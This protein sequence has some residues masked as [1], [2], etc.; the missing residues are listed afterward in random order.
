MPITV[1]K[2]SINTDY[3]LLECDS[4]RRSFLNAPPNSMKNRAL[5]FLLFACATNVACNDSSNPVAGSD[6][7]VSSSP[8]LAASKSEPIEDEYIV[9]FDDSESGVEVRAAKLVSGQKGKLKHTFKHGL[10]GFSATLTVDA[11][12]AIAN[13]PGV[14]RVESDV[15]M[16][17]STT[18]TPPSWGL[19]RID[20]RPLPLDNSY[21]FSSVGSGVRVYIVDTGILTGH[22]EFGSRAVSG[23]TAVSDGNGTNDCNGHGTHVA[24]TVGGATTGIAR[25]AQLVAVRV[26]DCSGSGTS[27]GVIA[28]IDWVVS[29][30][31]ANP[32]VPMVAN[33]SLGGS[34]NTSLND[35]VTR[36][37]AAGV[38]FA[39]AAG[40]SSV[41]A[42]TQ[43]PAATPGALTVGATESSDVMAYYSNFGT[44]LDIFAPGSGIVSAWYNG[45]Y[46]NLSG[47]SMAAPH[48]AGVAAIIL[49]DYP[50]Y[51]P[52]QVRS[53]LVTGA[54]TN[55]LSGT[56]AGSPNVLLSNLYAAAAPPPPPPP[57]PTPVTITLSVTGSR[58][59]NK[60]NANLFWGGATASTVSVYR[61]GTLRVNTSNDG[62]YSERVGAG[63]FA[64]KVCQSTSC[65]SVVTVTF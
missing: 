63:S 40:N 35:A 4:N 19:D 64:Y 46:A 21:T 8:R 48:V 11:A 47:T 30:K 45:G 37:I 26:L 41:D 22:Q 6:N 10:K 65:S 44:C 58:T 16:Q 49:G 25:A 7:I 20:Q 60:N 54:T 17:A 18:V 51:S 33:L 55:V 61:N 14:A 39:V 2:R 50:A 52:S 59:G 31:Q 38:V 15:V 12:A 9:T 57:P 24:G 3:H 53:A 5:P 62:S 43:S 13:M 34:L 36:A 32:S 27:A 1:S 29:Q 28:G 42:C 56:G 23:Y